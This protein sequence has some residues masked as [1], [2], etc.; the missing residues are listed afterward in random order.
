MS[1][2]PISQK[3]LNPVNKNAQSFSDPMSGTNFD[4]V[5][6][7]TNVSISFLIE[8]RDLGE[9]GFL[10]PPEQ[11]I[12]NNLEIMDALLEMDRT[13]RKLGYY[14]GTQSI[15]CSFSVILLGVLLALFH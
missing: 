10:L 13:T 4:W 9:Y 6:N 12:P 14:S 11:I 5:K 1:N 8:L 3:L 2:K 15:I 7:A